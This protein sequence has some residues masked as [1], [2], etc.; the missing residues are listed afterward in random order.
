MGRSVYQVWPHD[1]AGLVMLYLR[2][3][4]QG[5]QRSRAFVIEPPWGVTPLQFWGGGSRQWATN[6]LCWWSAM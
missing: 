4:L 5:T 6:V 3:T 1:T 2:L